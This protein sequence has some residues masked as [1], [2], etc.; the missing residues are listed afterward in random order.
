MQPIVPSFETPEALHAG[1]DA[2]SRFEPADLYPRDGS[3]LLAEVE[4]HIADLARTRPRAGVGVRVRH[5]C[6]NGRRRH[7][8]SSRESE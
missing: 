6:G 3:L 1:L 7:S 2:K 5:G 8:A 4:E